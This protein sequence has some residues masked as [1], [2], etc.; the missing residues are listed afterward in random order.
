[1]T[2]ERDAHTRRHNLTIRQNDMIEINA[3][4]RNHDGK[5]PS[6]GVEPC[7]NER[8]SMLAAAPGGWNHNT[9]PGDTGRRAYGVTAS[10]F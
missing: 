9:S 4:L 10:T 8:R 6:A 2:T 7:G 3:V 1:M 5:L